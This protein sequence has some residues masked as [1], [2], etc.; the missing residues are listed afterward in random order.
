MDYGK[1]IRLLRNVPFDAASEKRIWNKISFTVQGRKIGIFSLTDL[2]PKFLVPAVALA[3][4]A[5]IFYLN[6][7]KQIETRNFVQHVYTTQYIYETCK[8]DGLWN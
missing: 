6:Y 5:F 4:L 8:Y 3:A 2:W 1:F 7:A